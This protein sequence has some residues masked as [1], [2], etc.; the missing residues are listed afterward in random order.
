MSISLGGVR[1]RPMGGGGGGPVTISEH[2]IPDPK[3]WTDTGVDVDIGGDKHF[4]LSVF[5]VGNTLYSFGSRKTGNIDTNKIL[6]APY[7]STGNTPTWSDTGATMPSDLS[8][9]RIALIDNTLYCFGAGSGQGTTTTQIYTAPLSNPTVWSNTGATIDIRRDSATLV[10]ANNTIMIVG[11]YDNSI[12]SGKNTVG[13][14]S[15]SAPTSWSTSGAILPV[16]IWDNS[17]AV[18]GGNVMSIGGASPGQTSYCIRG[19]VSTSQPDFSSNATGVFS[20]GATCG[21][22]PYVIDNGN[23]VSLIGGGNT[24]SSAICAV[25]NELGTNAWQVVP[26]ASPTSLQYTSGWI[27]GD[28]RCYVV[29]F[30]TGRIFRSGRTKVYVPSTYVPSG[31]SAY[32][33]LLGYSTEAD[34]VQ[35]NGWQAGGVPTI[36]S[37]HVRMG[38]QPWLTNRTTAF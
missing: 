32:A 23:F 19:P 11:G 27:G 18:A 4:L 25:G 14:A 38:I 9:G 33:P 1:V 28:G 21:T 35:A 30:G 24:T 26:N 16:N 34:A 6:S 22:L 7:D 20:G 37:S 12:S 15:V 10:I 5:R 3:T 36:V 31:A 29:N 8:Y 17:T 13:Y 2:W